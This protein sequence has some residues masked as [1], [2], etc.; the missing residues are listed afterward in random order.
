MISICEI[1]RQSQQM[2]EVS[3]LSKSTLICL[4]NNAQNSHYIVGIDDSGRKYY[5]HKCFMKLK[6]ATLIFLASIQ[7]SSRSKALNK[8]YENLLSGF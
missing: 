5:L 7:L 1:K 2:F 8:L 3:Q 4:L 6:R